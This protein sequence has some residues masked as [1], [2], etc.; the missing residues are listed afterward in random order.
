MRMV[1]RVALVLWLLILGVGLLVT[2]QPDRTTVRLNACLPN[3]SGC[4]VDGW[5]GANAAGLFVTLAASMLVFH[6]WARWMPVWS[7]AVFAV[8]TGILSVVTGVLVVLYVAWADSTCLYRL[9]R[10]VDAQ[11]GT[12]APSFSY[13]EVWPTWAVGGAVVAAAGIGVIAWRS[14]RADGAPGN[15]RPS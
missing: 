4:A 11:C 12:Q 8:G 1:E 7:R 6:G 10:G 15:R 9:R 14:W 2:L 13:A 5:L 3:E